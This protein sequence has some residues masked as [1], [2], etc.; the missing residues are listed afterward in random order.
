[1]YSMITVHCYEPI[2]SHQEQAPRQQWQGKPQFQVGGYYRRLGD[3]LK[4]S[5]IVHVK[6]IVMDGD[7]NCWDG[8]STN[9][10]NTKDNTL[11]T[12]LT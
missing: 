6:V 8:S 7:S 1:M 3:V 4:D 10:H 5:T 2:C 9:K 12:Q 11:V